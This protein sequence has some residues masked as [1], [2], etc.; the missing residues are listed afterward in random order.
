MERINKLRKAIS[1][2]FGNDH[3]EMYANIFRKVSW[4]E[5]M[6]LEMVLKVQSATDLELTRCQ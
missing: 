5:R 3:K 6:F 2:R 4:Q 1:D